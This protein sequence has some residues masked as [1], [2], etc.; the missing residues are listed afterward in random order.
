MTK[1]GTQ[2]AK[3]LRSRTIYKGPVFGIRR[4]ELIEPGGVRTSREMITHS[5]SVVVLPI[6]PDGRIL[7][8]RQYRH[9]A[10]QFLW[11]VGRL[12]ELGPLKAMLPILLAGKADLGPILDVKTFAIGLAPVEGLTMTGHFQLTDAK[13]AAKLK[14]RLEAVKVEGAKSQKVETPPPEVQTPWVTWQVRGDVNVMRRL[15]N[16]GQEVKK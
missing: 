8:I 9:A 5:G 14:N 16:Q 10:R 1:R 6:F 15:L 4:D 3:I 2:K 12:D 11:A 13:A 7:L